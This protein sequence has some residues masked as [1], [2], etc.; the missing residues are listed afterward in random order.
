MFLSRDQN[1]SRCHNIKTDNISVE[2][3]EHF[4]YLGSNLTNQISIH[5][6]IK[7]RLKSGNDCCHSVQNH[8]SSSLLS[9]N[10]K[11][12]IYR[13]IILLVVV[14]GCETWSLTLREERKLRLFQNMVLR[15]LFGPKRDE[16]RGDWRKLNDEE[17]NDLHS[18]PDI[19]RLIE[20]TSSSACNILRILQN[21]DLKHLSLQ[22][23]NFPTRFKKIAGSVLLFC[24]YTYPRHINNPFF[25]GGG[26]G[27]CKFKHE[28]VKKYRR[29]LYL[30]LRNL[31]T[32]TTLI[33]NAQFVPPDMIS[34]PVF[35]GYLILSYLKILYRPLEISGTD[36]D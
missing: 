17:L 21:I 36:Q 35:R 34:E 6:E 22:F 11:I 8:L 19:F 2:R 15:R 27:E 28:N 5:E 25:W 9:K 33:G 29:F 31:G 16:V 18:S 10:I 14:Y 20:T 13:T 23:H 32:Q 24:I 4:R 1:A 26:R 30:I 7:S 12:K 3:V